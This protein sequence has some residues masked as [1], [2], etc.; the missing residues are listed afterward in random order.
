[1]HCCSGRGCGPI[2]GVVVLLLLRVLLVL[3]LLL[4]S[5]RH[6]VQLLAGCLGHCVI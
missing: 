3:V 1:M 6:R 5:G 4:L 2:E